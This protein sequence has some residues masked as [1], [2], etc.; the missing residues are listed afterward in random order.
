MC[1]KRE[2]S[3]K[4]R[5]WRRD[6]RLLILFG[7][8]LVSVLHCGSGNDK[9]NDKAAATEA[10]SSTTSTCILGTAKISECKVN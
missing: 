1:I 4:L 9:S 3:G 7:L 2:D 8:F 5:R 10:T 6:T